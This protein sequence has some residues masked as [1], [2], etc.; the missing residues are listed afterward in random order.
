LVPDAN[1]ADYGIAFFALAG[2]IFLVGRTMNLWFEKQSADS[3]NETITRVTEVVQNNT[4]ALEHLANIIQI[5]MA[6]QE[7]KID[8]IVAHIRRWPQ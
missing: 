4:Q 7:A 1:I 6:K 2:I 3:I 8:E 5:N